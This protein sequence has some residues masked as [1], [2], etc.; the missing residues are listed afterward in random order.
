MNKCIVCNRL[1]PSLVFRIVHDICKIHNEKRYRWRDVRKTPP[2]VAREMIH[3]I[4]VET[5]KI[6][7]EVDQIKRSFFCGRSK[8]SLIGSL[9]YVISY[10]LDI[11]LTQDEVAE[12]C[13]AST[14]SIRNNYLRLK[15]FPNICHMIAKIQKKVQ[16]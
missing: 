9:I 12:G 13:H 16:V 2:I 6:I 15:Q 5:C 11:Y 3:Q 7:F 1:T 8:Y 4:A 10:Q 14:N